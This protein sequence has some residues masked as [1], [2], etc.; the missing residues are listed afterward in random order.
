MKKLLVV[1]AVLLVAAPLMAKEIELVPTPVDGVGVPGHFYSLPPAPMYPGEYELSHDDGTRSYMWSGPSGFASTFDLTS[2]YWVLTMKIFAYTYGETYDEVLDI[3]GWAGSYPD[4]YDSYFGGSLTFPGS[5]PY[6]DEWAEFDVS[7]EHL[8][9]PNGDKITLFSEGG[10]Y[11]LYAPQDG[12]SGAPAQ[13]GWM[14]FGGTTWFDY[15]AYGFGAMMI[16]AIVNDDADGP[17]GDNYNPA[18]GDTAP[19]DTNVV[20]HCY[21]DDIGVDSDTIN[22]DSMLVEV[23][24]SKVSGTITITGDPSDYEVTF[25][26]DSDFSEGDTVNV[27]LSPSGNEILDQLTNSMEEVTYS[28]DIGAYVTVQP[29]SL[30]YI[31]AMYE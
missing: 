6:A 5:G 16:R 4:I 23:A 17:Y 15:S 27:T 25:D 10:F 9:L 8:F 11:P 31:K 12:N 21:D 19:P 1:V 13:S 14:W 2:D 24:K 22:T 30:G 28:F 26:P 3:L 7:D 18:D 20:W 29:T